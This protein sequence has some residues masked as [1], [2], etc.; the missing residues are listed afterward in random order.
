MRSLHKGYD[1]SSEIESQINKHNTGFPRNIFKVGLYVNKHTQDFELATQ[2]WVVL[3]IMG[4]ITI[5]HP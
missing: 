1:G 3:T 4:M 2:A 5:R